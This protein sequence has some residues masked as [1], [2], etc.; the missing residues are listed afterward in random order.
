MPV[1]N[2]E[3]YL[4]EALESVL[5]Q[6]LSDFEL[7]VYDDGSQDAT[8]EILHELRDPR[9]R[10]FRQNANQGIFGNLNAAVREARAPLL[11]IFCQD[12]R[13]HPDCLQE[14][15]AL[16][17]AHPEAGMVF[18]RF[19]PLD[20]R[21]AIIDPDYAPRGSADVPRYIPPRR[22]LRL[23]AAFGC[24]PGNLSPVMLRASAFRAVGAFD[25]QLRYAGDFEYWV[26]LGR[27]YPILFNPAKLMGVRMHPEQGSHTL[28]RRFQLLRQEIPIWQDLIATAFAPEERARAEIFVT[29]IRGVQYLHGFLRAAL[30][31]RWTAIPEGIRQLQPPFTLPRLI[32]AYLWTFNSRRMP[33][34]SWIVGCDAPPPTSAEQLRDMG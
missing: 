9:L 25:P 33:D 4:R 13:M 19:H 23:F 34:H 14:Q 7:I 27:R 20:E 5:T 30:L 28:N 32:R 8:L 15:Q 12:D 6:R 3:R 26:R 1:Y 10:V 16:L 24:M 17:R 22:A 21:G 18:C 29:R 31:G 11:Q 2:G